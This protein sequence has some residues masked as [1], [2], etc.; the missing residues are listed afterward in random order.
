MLLGFKGAL[1]TPYRDATTDVIFEPLDF[2][3]HLAAL[4]PKP[5]VNLTR[6]Y[7]VSAPNARHRA[8]VTPAKQGRGNQARVVEERPAPAERRSSLPFAQRRKRVFDI[9]IKTCSECTGAVKVI[10]CIEDPKVLKQ[11]LKSPQIQS[12]NP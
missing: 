12:P 5:R 7:G 4:V 1:K 3:A 2:I 9:D 8:R 6:F 11:I 10:A